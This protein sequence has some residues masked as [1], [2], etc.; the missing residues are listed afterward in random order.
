MEDRSASLIQE[1]IDRE[2]EHLRAHLLEEMAKPNPIFES[3]KKI[4]IPP[5]EYRPDRLDRDC[6]L[7]NWL[8]EELEETLS[9]FERRH[10]VSVSLSVSDPYEDAMA[11]L[12][13]G[14]V[15]DSFSRF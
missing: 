7:W 1:L 8:A 3:L 12:T 15:S 5:P 6:V 11:E 14:S 10:G 13:V 4:P 9:R 2:M